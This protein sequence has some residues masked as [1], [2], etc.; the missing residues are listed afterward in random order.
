VNRHR[1][2][3]RSARGGKDRGT[4]LT[5]LLVVMLIMGVVAAATTALTIG[6]QRTNAE[7]VA[8]QDQIDTARTAVEAITKTIR[9]AVKPVQISAGCGGCTQDAFVTGSDFSVQFYANLNNQKNVVGPSRVRYAVSTAG[10]TIGQL[11]ETIQIPDPG[12]PVALGYSYCDALLVTATTDC[13]GRLSTRPVGFGILT[14]AG[15][16]IFKYYDSLGVRMTPPSGASLTP[17]DLA[18]VLSVEIVVQA[19]SLT[20]T[21]VPATTYIQRVMLPNAEAVIRQQKDTP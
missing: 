18:K 11:V 17:G 15:D 10:A 21:T 8:R 6:F 19:K 3:A 5:E 13:K 4:T 2:R 1:V 12:G 14:P 16:P 20:V 9:T 7:G